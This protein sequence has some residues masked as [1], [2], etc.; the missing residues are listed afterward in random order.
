M[1]DTSPVTSSKPRV[2][3]DF[4]K[5]VAAALAVG[6]TASA[7]A[8]GATLL[9]SRTTNAAATGTASTASGA[10]S[11]AAAVW[12]RQAASDTTGGMTGG[13]ND[14]LLM[15]EEEIPTWVAIDAL[16]ASN[17][18]A[19][20]GL[21]DYQL[22]M[23]GNL[24]VGGGCDSAPVIASERDWSVEIDGQLARVRVMQTFVMPNTGYRTKDMG[25]D[26]AELQ[27]PAWFHTVLPE[28][29]T[30]VGM[31]IESDAGVRNLPV[32]VLTGNWQQDQAVIDDARE[33]S[34]TNARAPLAMLT[35]DGTYPRLST[36]ELLTYVAGETIVVTYEY[37]VAPS[38]H[39]GVRG[40]DL[41]LAPKVVSALDN[42]IN[43]TA[44]AGSAED[45]VQVSHADDVAS[46][47]A[48]P[49]G[50]V[51]IAWVGAQPTELIER[52]I[53]VS[54]ERAAGASGYGTNRTRGAI[55]GAAW[56]SASIADND[57]FKLRWK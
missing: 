56:S 30:L 54:V 18:D 37:T 9:L 35:L 27:L 7:A 48:Q 16:P 55:I 33:V 6:V 2:I 17:Q 49:Q 15:L 40:I 34:A 19:D 3:T 41:P 12:A 31:Q 10:P 51:W 45:A 13:A 52:P 11:A 25:D 53:G 29:A 5:L 4:A 26:A 22:P 42:T 36:D 14:G 44:D 43:D 23:P 57:T 28:G 8:V 38:E 50:S 47:I 39:D 21:L 20:D 46:L 24:Y 1:Q 32:I